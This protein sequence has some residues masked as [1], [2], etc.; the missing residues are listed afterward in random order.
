M[1]R[2]VMG[3]MTRLAAACAFAAALPAAALA[4][5][6][7]SAG[8]PATFQG[9]D[10][11]TQGALA[12]ALAKLTGAPATAPADGAADVTMEQ[13]DRALVDALGLRDTAYRF[14]LAARRAGLN[15]PRRFGTEVVEI[16]RAS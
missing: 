1:A 6:S 13:L 9:G 15:P 8:T 14:W 3:R 12:A 11:L 5:G 7:G 16:G 2:E 4:A 10:P